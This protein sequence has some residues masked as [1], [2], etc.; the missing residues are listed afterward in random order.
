MLKSGRI[1]TVGLARK[2]IWRC[3]LRD[4][5]RDACKKNEFSLLMIVSASLRVFRPTSDEVNCLR[6]QGVNSISI[7]CPALLLSC[8]QIPFPKDFL[9]GRHMLF[10]YRVKVSLNLSPEIKNPVI[11]SN[12]IDRRLLLH[13]L[14]KIA[15]KSPDIAFAEIPRPD[16]R[17]DGYQV[18]TYAH[19]A[20]ACP[21]PSSPTG[22]LHLPPGQRHRDGEG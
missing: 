9:S 22:L 11:M 18:V 15:S 20:Q 6:I 3:L 4:G 7:D 19:L 8:F 21:S 16:W 12:S 2:A 17:K 14:D 13:V 1:P 5:C 10:F